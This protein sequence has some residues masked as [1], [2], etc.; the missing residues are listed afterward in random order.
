VGGY[1]RAAIH[2]AMVQR[3]PGLI[4]WLPKDKYVWPLA[5]D[6]ERVVIDDPLQVFWNAADTLS[7][8]YFL[9]NDTTDRIIVDLRLGGL[10]MPKVGQKLGIHPET[11]RRRL[12]R[13]E[14]EFWRVRR[15]EDRLSYQGKS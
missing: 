12:L 3:D 11:V 6:V 1:L 2:N 8:I 10:S 14:V 15:G 5:M 9:C 13:L 7:L 4:K